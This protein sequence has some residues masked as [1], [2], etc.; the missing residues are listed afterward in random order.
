MKNPF[1]YG[2]TVTG[3]NFC[4]RKQE[5]TE[6]VNDINK[7]LKEKCDLFFSTTGMFPIFSWAVKRT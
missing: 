3:E 4:N 5:I 7:R 1:V 2:E 6:L